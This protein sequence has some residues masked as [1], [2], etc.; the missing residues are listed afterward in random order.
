MHPPDGSL[1]PL[2]GAETLSCILPQGP[3]SAH[4]ACRGQKQIE[5]GLASSN[6][7]WAEM[8]EGGAEGIDS[9]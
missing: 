8:H 1:A 3:I 7:T 9:V 4:A 2:P 6:G 5:F